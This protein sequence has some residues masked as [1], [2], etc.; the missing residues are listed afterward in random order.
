VYEIHV[1]YLILCHVL[2]CKGIFTTLF[3]SLKPSKLKCIRVWSICCDTVCISLRLLCIYCC[4]KA[5]LNALDCTVVKWWHG[6]NLMDMEC[7]VT[8]TLSLQIC[9]C[10]PFLFIKWLSLRKLMIHKRVI[11]ILSLV[12]ALRY[13]PQGRC[14]GFLMV[15]LEFFLLT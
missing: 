2:L 7:K 11:K 12:E 13:K 10:A 3:V 15:W 1:T 8:V 6:A 9:V 4:I 14:F 5:N